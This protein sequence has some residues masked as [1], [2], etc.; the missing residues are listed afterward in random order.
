MTF[1]PRNLHAFSR[2]KI[3]VA[4]LGRNLVNRRNVKTFT[5]REK[6]FSSLPF[7]VS[8]TDR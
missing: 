6:A 8:W 1:L 3:T 4:H 2:L 7:P 5:R